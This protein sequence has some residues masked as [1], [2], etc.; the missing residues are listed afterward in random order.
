MSTRDWIYELLQVEVYEGEGRRRK[1]QFEKLVNLL[2]MNNSNET[3][4][5]IAVDGDSSA[6]RKFMSGS[7]ALRGAARRQK[8]L[9]VPAKGSKKSRFVGAPPEWLAHYGIE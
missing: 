6:G 1:V 9:N 2:R 4:D 3:A 5:K 7:N 8:G